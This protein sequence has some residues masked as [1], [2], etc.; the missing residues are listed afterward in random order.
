MGEVP[1][2][3]C[4]GDGGAEPIGVVA[5]GD[6]QLR[7]GDGSNALDRHESGVG[8]GRSDAHALL[9]VCG[10]LDQVLVRRASD[11]SECITSA[12]SSSAP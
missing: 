5:G 8:A 9:E 1:Q 6:E 2:E 12:V 11:R 7:C 4:E 10:L 3:G